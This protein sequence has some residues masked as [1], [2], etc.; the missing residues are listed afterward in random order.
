MTHDIRRYADCNR[1]PMSE[2]F[3]TRDEISALRDELRTKLRGLNLIPPE[4][5][6]ET[7][8][9]LDSLFSRTQEHVQAMSDQLVMWEGTDQNQAR[10]FIAETNAE[11]QSLSESYNR[12][13][14]RFSLLAGARTDISGGSA[15]QK[16]ALLDTRRDIDRGA[17]LLSDVVQSLDDIRDAGQGVREEIAMQAGKENLINGRIDSLDNESAIGRSII[18]R[19]WRREKIRTAAI[20]IVV[21]VVI[22]GL[23]V[24]LY[25]VFR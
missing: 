20:W 14:S 18:G 16:T 17:A 24:F 1:R 6:P 15:G 9:D 21:G 13:K 8:R 10:R 25:F 22:V 12:D 5:R 11:L 2:F 4:R 7:L 23:G 3:Q 19:M